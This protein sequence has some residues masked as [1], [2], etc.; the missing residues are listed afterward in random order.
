MILEPHYIANRVAIAI[1]EDV[2]KGDITAGLLPDKK[3]KATIITR[4][5]AIICGC[6]FV[7]EVYR[8]LDPDIK[9][10]W[11]VK[12]GDSI[13]PDQLLCQLEGPVKSLLTGE[14]IALN[15]LQT[16]SG[17]ATVT[18]QYV[19]ALYHTTTRLLDTR[20]TLPGLRLAQ[21]YAVRCGGGD[22][23]R[24]GLFDAF[25]IK[26]NHITACGSIKQAIAKARAEAPN[27]K[28]EVEVE[29]LDELNEALVEKADIIMLD[30]FTL[31]LMKQ[32]VIINAGRSKLEVSGN[33]NVTQLKEVA[34][35]GVDFISV[36][37]LTKHIK[38][39]DLSMRLV[40]M[41]D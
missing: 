14:R 35:T 13:K 10:I 3:A 27:K 20:K 33:I 36:G 9:L 5:K 7:S 8:Q 38:A 25:L 1:D 11:Q 6:E 30:N 40:G 22:N 32:A 4:E 16:L 18:A 29:N 12:D 2:G 39:I 15:F 41:C 34:A 17:T 23:H 28:V 37:A 19:D 21:K 24:L 31:D 26:E